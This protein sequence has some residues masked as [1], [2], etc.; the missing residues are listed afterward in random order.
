MTSEKNKEL[1]FN[2]AMD[3]FIS[4]FGNLTHDQVY[5][6]LSNDEIPDEILIWE[7]FENY[8]A[9]YLL[10]LMDNLSNVMI[11]FVWKLWDIS[12]KEVESDNV[13]RRKKEEFMRK[14]DEEIKKE[15]I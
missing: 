2:Y 11:D 12:E 6:A 14:C 5:E 8:G 7:P 3:Y 4:D 15:Q 9:Y 10:E 1:A 13:E